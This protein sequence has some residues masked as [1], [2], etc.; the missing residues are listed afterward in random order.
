MS[1]EHGHEGSD[2]VQDVTHAAHETS[3]S[4]AVTWAARGG[5]VV[6]GLLHLL[7]AWIAFRVAVGTTD[8]QASQSG[9]LQTISSTP[10]GQVV[11]WLGAVGFLAFAVWEV[12]DAIRDRKRRRRDRGWVDVA[13]SAA[14]AV[15]HLAIGVACLRFAL[16]EP[17]NSKHSSQELSA[18]L[19]QH[20][21]GRLLVGAIGLV[22]VGVGLYHGYKGATR[23]FLDDLRG[24][25][26][27]ASTT[28][29][30]V[31]Y[32]AKGL[33]LV[34]VGGLFVAAAVHHRARQA[35]G[36]DGALRDL[37]QQPYGVVLLG[38]VAAGLAAYG[39]YTLSTLHRRV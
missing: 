14:T 6:S 32:L 8:H 4:P 29:G 31:G 19:M 28:A 5:L 39:L 18:V 23:G 2:V 24:E 12:A 13:K 34:L 36:L 21:G 26:N 11:L 22:V 16:G 37:Q 15:V 10:G 3:E 7:I 33:A 38:A 17:S 35:S 25:P 30:I 1:S 20:A 9:A 27:L